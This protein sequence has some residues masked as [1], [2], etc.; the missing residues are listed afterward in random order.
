MPQ[1]SEILWAGSE[2]SLQVALEAQ[3]KAIE[4][5]KTVDLQGRGMDDYINDMVGSVYEPVGSIGLINIKGSL[6][7][8]KAGYARLWGVTGY[9]DIRAAM[10]QAVADQNIDA[11]MLCV[12]SGGGAVAG[13][14]D[15]SDYMQSVDA[16]K[17]LLTYTETVM[18]S[19]ALWLG[20]NGRQVLGSA[21]AIMGSIG[22]LMTHVDATKAME[23]QG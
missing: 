17:P 5:A 14:Q 19:A 2:A 10:T 8:G 4:Y 15:L 9:D 7:N 6:I 3:N 16:V 18:A 13:V 11:I 21:T 1:A 22:V 20:L 23:M 12:N